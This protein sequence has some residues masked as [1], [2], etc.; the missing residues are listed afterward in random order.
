MRQGYFGGLTAGPDLFPGIPCTPLTSCC[1]VISGVPAPVAC[2]GTLGFS[3]PG[4]R[5]AAPSPTVTAGAGP[6][7][8]PGS[9]GVPGL[10]GPVLGI[11]RWLDSLGTPGFGSLVS[12]QAE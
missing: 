8:L 11:A 3:P 7:L 4:V 2:G 1:L 6:D 5:M 9:P 12:D 10:D